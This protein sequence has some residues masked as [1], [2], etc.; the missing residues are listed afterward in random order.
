[1][2]FDSFIQPGNF[3]I[4]YIC[5]TEGEAN[6]VATGGGAG[7]CQAVGGVTQLTDISVAGLFGGG[8]TPYIAAPAGG[9]GFYFLVGRITDSCVDRINSVFDVEWGCEVQAPPGGIASTSSGLTA[10]D[11]A[12]LSTQSVFNSLDVD[13]ELTGTNT[14]QPMGS[15]GT[16]T[17]RISNIT[18]GTI[19]GGA[20]GIRLRDILPV[21]Y[22]VDSTFTPTVQMAPAYGNT[23]LGMLDTIVWT[24]PQP[25][26][27]PLTTDQ[28]LTGFPLGNVAPE[29]TITSSTT[30]T[31]PG[32][33]DQ[34]NLL[35]HGDVLTVTFQAV[36]I[37][38]QYYDR[39]AYLDVRME[40]PAS[41]PPGTDPT[42]SFPITNQLDI[43]FS[44][45]C[46]NI[47]HQ[48]TFND[49]D[50]AQPEDIDVDIIG[51]ELVFILTNTD[52]LPL[53][54][55]LRNNGGHDADDY[56]AYV[57]FG[58]AMTVQTAPG[59]CA[60]TSNPPVMPV[61]Q[62]P[63]TLPASATVYQCDVGTIRAGTTRN[64]NFEVVVIEFL[65]YIVGYTVT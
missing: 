39:E 7:N 36:L 12:L 4:D 65:D 58:E 30:N 57:T 29:F 64:L 8:P 17:I 50:D 3:E 33:P 61:W 56:F 47:E 19:T 2:V 34:F 28:S 52:V 23:Y 51:T 14:S 25:N 37:D 45:Y 62:D 6:S 22:V 31:I 48:L 40:E 27:V 20:G 24:N 10:Q 32:E 43:W 5:E 53:T 11:D 35:R 26:T 59:A 16:V 42:E 63:V 13:V 60:E 9:S 18:G 46:T 49:N 54:V 38:P 55:R 21:E 15:R 1:M 44:E 41:D